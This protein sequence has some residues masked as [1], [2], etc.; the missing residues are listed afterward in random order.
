MELIVAGVF[1]GQLRTG[2]AGTAG[3]L[4]AVMGCGGSFLLN[5]LEYRRALAQKR[6]QGEADRRQE[7]FLKDQ[8]KYGDKSF[9]M[10]HKDK[11]STWIPTWWPIQSLPDEEYKQMLED[12]QRALNARLRRGKD[13]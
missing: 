7:Q 4:G 8:E 1:N 3:M 12:K 13:T 10:V 2:R 11:K 9:D 6:R 5:M